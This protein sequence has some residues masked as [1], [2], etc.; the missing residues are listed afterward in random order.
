MPKWAENIVIAFARMNGKTVGFVGNQ[1]LKQA[2]KQN[3]LVQTFNDNWYC[4]EA[5]LEKQE[6]LLK[7]R[8]QNFYF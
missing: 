3:L 7:C 8:K 5:L 4:S 2:G 6:L 1:P